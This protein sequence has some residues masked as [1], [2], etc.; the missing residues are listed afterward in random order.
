MFG[1]A[2][3]QDNRQE[4]KGFDVKRLFLTSMVLVL[5]VSV[6]TI[7]AQA[8]T[9]G[10]GLGM[11][12]HDGDFGFQFRKDLAVGGDLSQLTSQIG[13][14]FPSHNTAMTFDVDYHFIIK[15]ESGTSRFYPL[16]GLGFKTDFDFFKFGVNAGGGVNFMLTDTM[17]AF[18]EAKYV[19]SDWDGFGFALG[20]YF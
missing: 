18:A 12:L 10:W 2:G 3:R 11:Q 17:A 1:G 6:F 9:R 13:M 16:V 20:F 8:E 15:N 5:A 4:P 14:I 7:P 19:F